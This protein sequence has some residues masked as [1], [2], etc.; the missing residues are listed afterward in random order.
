MD[1]VTYHLLILLK[2]IFNSLLVHYEHLSIMNSFKKSPIGFVKPIGDK[3]LKIVLFI[4]KNVANIVVKQYR[5]MNYYDFMTR[6]IFE[7]QKK[8]LNH[9]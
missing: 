8:R 7:V 6:I 4:N 1:L 2:K 3:F 5:K 9:K